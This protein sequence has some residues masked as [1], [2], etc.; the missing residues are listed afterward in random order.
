MNKKH[1]HL[2][3]LLGLL[4]SSIF[5]FSACL[6][7][8][9]TILLPDGDSTIVLPFN[10]GKIPYDVIPQNLQDSLVIY[11]F[12]IFEGTCPPNI[13][14]EYLISPMELS[15]A[16]D[17]Y[18]NDFVNLRMAFKGQHPR[19][20]IHYYES[21]TGTIDDSASGTSIHASVIGHDSCFT[22]YAIQ[23]VI[24][25]SSNGLVNYRCKTA[26]I[27][28]GTMIDTGIYNCKY[29][30]ILLEKWARTEYYA[31]RL[32]ELHTFRIWFD[33]DTLAVKTSKTLHK[34]SRK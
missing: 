25:T 23:N 4:L 19:G 13:N 33:G 6:K 28:S 5:V 17:N 21:Q 20:R 15:H 31:N 2:G 32:P 22:M 34:P 1:R 3:L 9:S 29:S 24:D 7:D 27:V 8:E 18:L 26:T 16:S 30:T 12:D 14:G 10:T 11:G